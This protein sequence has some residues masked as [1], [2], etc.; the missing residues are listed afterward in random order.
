M[1]KGIQGHSM[2]NHPP[3]KKKKKKKKKKYI[4]FNPTILYFDETWCAC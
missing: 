2:S 1:N 3:P 4:Y